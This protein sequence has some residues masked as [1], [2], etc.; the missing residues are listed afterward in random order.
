M[1]DGIAPRD[2]ILPS[3][4]DRQTISLTPA[5]PE[6]EAA[7]EQMEIRHTSFLLRNTLV[8]QSTLKCGNSVEHWEHIFLTRIFDIELAYAQFA[9]NIQV[10]YH[11][12][13]IRKQLE[14]LSFEHSQLIKSD[15]MKNALHKGLPD[16]RAAVSV[17][18][19]L[20]PTMITWEEHRRKIVEIEAHLNFEF[21]VVWW[22][23]P[24]E[25][26]VISRSYALIPL[27]EGSMKAKREAKEM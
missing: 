22:E 24:V 14:Q 6:A 16:D 17:A 21:G 9:S 13:E 1:F 25:G 3:R 23:R 4:F 26:V 18:M 2:R 19:A 11:L 27:N 20:N 10:I 8:L 15:E 5:A 12:E 7:W